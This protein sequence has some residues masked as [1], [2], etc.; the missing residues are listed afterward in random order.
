MEEEKYQRTIQQNKA[1]HKYFT[2]LAEEL[3]NAGLDMKKVLKP[4]V[5]IDWTPDAIK[6]YLWKPV[7]KVMYQTTSTTELDTKQVSQIYETLNRHLAEKFGL[8]VRFPS[9]EEMMI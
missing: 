3:N 9:N 5:D 4:A 7:Q 1:M 6:T 2:L 8:S